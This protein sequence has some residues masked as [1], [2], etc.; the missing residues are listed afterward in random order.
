MI[1]WIVVQMNETSTPIKEL[2]REDLKQ[3]DNLRMGRLANGFSYVMLPNKVPPQRFEA[4][5]EMHA[6]ILHAFAVQHSQSFTFCLHLQQSMHPSPL[7]GVGCDL[8]FFVQIAEL[9]ADPPSSL[10]PSSCRC[11]RVMQ[12]CAML[13]ARML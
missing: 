13:C 6:G 9:S 10:R 5:L 1:R 7:P 3:A 2:L 4:H 11:R 8:L 12:H